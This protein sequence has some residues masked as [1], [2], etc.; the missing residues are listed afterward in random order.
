MFSVDCI[1]VDLNLLSADPLKESAVW[2][3]EV[4][5]EELRAR[6][7]SARP[8]SPQINASQDPLGTGTDV[9]GSVHSN[10]HCSHLFFCISIPF[11]DPGVGHGFLPKYCLF[12]QSATHPVLQALGSQAH[13][14]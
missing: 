11:S 14:S 4:D 2:L 7:G 5:P 6:S 3:E 9:F 1:H 8:V 12:L 10:S 13:S